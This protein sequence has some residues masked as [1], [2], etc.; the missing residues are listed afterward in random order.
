MPTAN[1]EFLD[2]QL[3]HAIG[4]QRFTAGEVQTILAMLD[5]SNAEIAARLSLRLKPDDFTSQRFIKLMRE[6]KIARKATMLS[7]SASTITRLRG[8]RYEVSLSST[9]IL[10]F[11]AMTGG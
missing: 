3:R 9:S 6:I 10:S 8:F 2:A 4:V 5:R 11:C 7:R 1:E